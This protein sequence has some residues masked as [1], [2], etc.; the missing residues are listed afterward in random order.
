MTHLRNLGTA[1]FEWRPGRLA[2]HGGALLGWMLLRAAAQAGTVVLL[3]RTLAART[4][5]EFVA[6]I[7]VAISDFGQANTKPAV[8]VGPE[9][10][11]ALE[12]YALVRL[13]HHTELEAGADRGRIARPNQF[14][15]MISH[16]LRSKP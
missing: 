6:V 15:R 1:V 7:A 16:R 11:F 3:A 12:L 13:A 9:S 2:Q 4:Y 5:G 10:V 8:I 14:G